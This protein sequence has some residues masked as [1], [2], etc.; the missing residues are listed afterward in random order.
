MLPTPEIQEE[1]VIKGSLEIQYVADLH[2]TILFLF[3]LAP[4]KA[5]G[6]LHGETGIA[7]L[8]YVCLRDCGVALQ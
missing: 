7:V 3:P 4:I 2:F 8:H 5:W 1:I 6:G